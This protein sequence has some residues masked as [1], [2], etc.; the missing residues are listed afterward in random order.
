MDL[1]NVPISQTYG[2]KTTIIEDTV[3]LI[4]DD[5]NTV[6]CKPLVSCQIKAED[7]KAQ[8][9][10]SQIKINTNHPFKVEADA[11]GLSYEFIEGGQKSWSD[12]RFYAHSQGG[13][14]ATRV[15]AL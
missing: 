8:N 2:A 13:R 12:A 6:L 9:P 1:P 11:S 14:I 3:S 5:G 4:T 15:E 7:C 10:F